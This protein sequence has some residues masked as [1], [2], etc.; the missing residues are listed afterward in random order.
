MHKDIDYL[1][2]VSTLGILKRISAN[3][4]KFGWYSIVTA[5]DQLEGAEKIPPSYYVLKKL[6]ELGYVRKD[7][8]DDSSNRATYW[9][10]DSGRKL[11]SQRIAQERSP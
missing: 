6:V 8:P 11:L 1:A 5:V 4:G 2:L 7:P 3:D 9:I 10:T